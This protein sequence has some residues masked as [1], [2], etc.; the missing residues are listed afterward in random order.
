MSDAGLRR[1][2]PPGR[3]VG[4]PGRQVDA[5]GLVILGYRPSL[6]G[7]QSGGDRPGH[8]ELP[9]ETEN[10]EFAEHFREFLGASESKNRT[11]T[12]T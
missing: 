9:A 4:A 5:K 10:A 8:P 11:R 2:D 6:R 3:S 12:T 7:W 1:R